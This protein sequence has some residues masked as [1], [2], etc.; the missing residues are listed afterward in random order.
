MRW[1]DHAREVAGNA[2]PDGPFRG[3]PFLLKDLSAHYAGQPLTNGNAALREAMPVSTADTTLVSRFRG[4]G[5]VTLGRTNSPELGSVPVTE[6]V[7]YG[8]DPQ[9]VERRPRARRIERRSGRRRRRR[10]W[11]RSPTP[12]TVAARS[13]S[14]PR[15]AGWS[16]SSRRRDGSRSGR[17]RTENGLSVQLCVSRTVRDTAAPARCRARARRRRHRDRSVAGPPVRRRGRRRSRPAPDRAARPSSPRRCA[18]RRLRRP[19]FVTRRGCSSRS[20]TTSRP[21][22]RRRSRTKRSCVVS[23]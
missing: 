8:A 19:P 16:A 14:P 22:S 7:A 9:P 5:L 4:A 2:L 11:C 10:G 1:F 13:G 23:W 15:V 20:A 12:P 18:P 6:P 17:S 3:V 21:A